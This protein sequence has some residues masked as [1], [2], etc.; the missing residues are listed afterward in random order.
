[1][2]LKQGMPALF[3]QDIEKSKR[4]YVDILGF[5]I[6]FDFGTNVSF[7]EGFA[8]WQISK[9]HLISQSLNC[10]ASDSMRTNRFELYFETEE[11]EN[12]F[13]TLKSAKVKFL[14]PIHE[15]RWGQRTIRF[16]DPD[17]HLIEIGESIAQFVLRFYNQG[18][19]VE[20]VSERT[21][22]PINNINQILYVN[23]KK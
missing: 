9:E 4:F 3:V 18:M 2:N 22:V 5:N 19:T 14:H 20:Q 10:K 16:F 7:K 11:L 8:I 15:E 6:E 17:G 12:D 13:E 21:S 23:S 1:M